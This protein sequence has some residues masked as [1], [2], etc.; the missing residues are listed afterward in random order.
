MIETALAPYKV[1]T[2]WRTIPIL[3]GSEF[4]SDV[5]K[6]DRYHFEALGTVRDGS[7]STTK[8]CHIRHG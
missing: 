8:K 1:G 4:H 6:P 7:K 5:M 3:I 2:N